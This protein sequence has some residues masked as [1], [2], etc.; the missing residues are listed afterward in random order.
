MLVTTVELLD[1][2]PENARKKARAKE[3]WEDLQPMGKEAKGKARTASRVRVEAKEEKGRKEAVGR[4]EG[5]ITPRTVQK[6]VE[7]GRAKTNGEAR[8]IG[9]GN[10]GSQRS[11]KLN[12]CAVYEKLTQARINGRPMDE[13]EQV[14]KAWRSGRW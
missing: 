1:I 2:S 11:S 4:V 3:D 12:P 5:R 14:E 13:E 10:T 6:A 9:V 8:H 7:K